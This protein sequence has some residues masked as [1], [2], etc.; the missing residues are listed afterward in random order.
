M[1]KFINSK[2]FSTTARRL[3]PNRNEREALYSEARE[4]QEE[5][6]ATHGDLNCL[7]NKAISDENLATGYESPVAD[8]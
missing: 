3:L 4:L 6:D 8:N 1:I 2:P 7:A 5:F